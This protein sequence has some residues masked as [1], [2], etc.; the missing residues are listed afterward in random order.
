MGSQRPQEGVLGEDKS[1]RVAHATGQEDAASRGMDCRGLLSP[2][3]GPLM[4]S[5]LTEALMG[6]AP[7]RGQESQEEGQ[8]ASARAKP[9]P[10]ALTRDRDTER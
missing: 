8:K 4:R 5:L 2:P 9:F 3:P 1:L 6:P 10:S 7:C